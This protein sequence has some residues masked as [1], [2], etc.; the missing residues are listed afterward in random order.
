MNIKE[1]VLEEC[2]TLLGRA[3]TS[4]C[5]LFCQFRINIIG[6]VNSFVSLI[7]SANFE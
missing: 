1:L 7:I 5:E 3:F 2:K 6:V 4:C